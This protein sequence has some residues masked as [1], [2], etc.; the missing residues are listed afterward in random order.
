MRIGMMTDAYKPYVSG[1]TQYISLNKRYLEAAGHSVFV[2]TLGDMDYPDDELHIVRS[3][4]LPLSD[5]GFSF[6]FRYSKAARRKVQ[7][8]DVVH[9][10]HPFLTGRLALRYCKPRSIPVIFTNHTR[11]D[12]YTQA[13]L[14]FLPEQVGLTLLQAYLPRFADVCDLVVAPS[15][16]MERVLR[17][18]GVTCPV[19]IVPNGVELQ[20][21]LEP[22]HRPSRA[23]LGLPPG[24]LVLVYVGRLGP[25]KNL[26]LLLSAFAG[27]LDAYSELTLVIAGS[28]PELD[29]LRD[30]ARR[31]GIA[32]RV[33]FLGMVPYPELPGVLAAADIFVTASVSEAHPFSVI[34]ALAA[35]LPVLGID[36]PGVGDIIQDGHNGFL[37]QNGLAS[38]TARMVRLV[39]DEPARKQMAANARQSSYKFDIERTSAILLEHYYRLAAQGGKPRHGLAGLGDRLRSYFS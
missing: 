32:E 13:Y 9:V 31:A 1:V 17:Q 10:Q 8:M 2:F 5:T 6:N 19:E 22:A 14:P 15:A 27:A 33:I 39:M 18:L 38:F 23:E 16:G 20:P 12:L 21:F 28:G 35:S 37:S 29:H 25:E 34:E 11:Y 4:G 26:P 7:L 3:P 36:S 24:G 30:Q